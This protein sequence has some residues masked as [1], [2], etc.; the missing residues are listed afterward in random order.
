MSEFDPQSFLDATIAEP[1]S[2][3]PPV[4]PGSYPAEIGEPKPRNWASKDGSKSGVALDVPLTLM[5]DGAEAQRVGQEKVTITDSM[6]LDTTPAGGLDIAPGRN[7]RLRQYLEA[8]GLNNAGFSAR[9]LQGRQVRVAVAHKVD[10]GT[11]ETYER[12]GAVAKV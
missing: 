1:L 2:K 8:T 12:I 10:D 5:L 9:Q 7:R 6:F 11:G 3:R 4:N